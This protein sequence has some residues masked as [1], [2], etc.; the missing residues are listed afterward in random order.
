MKVMTFARIGVRQ[1][2]GS[3]DPKSHI[4]PGDLCEVSD[5]TLAGFYPV[6]YPTARGAKTRWVPELTGFLC[7]QNAYG[8][9]SYPA[10]GYPSATVKSGGC[11]VCAAVNAIGALCGRQV[12]V[13][14]M[15]DA[16]V[17]CGARVSGGT[18]MRRLTAELCRQYGL[19]C[20]VSGDVSALTAHLKAGG[21]AICNTAGRECSLPAGTMSPR[22]AC[23]TAGC[24]SRTRGCIPANTTAPG[25]GRRWGSAATWC[26][27]LPPLWTPTARGGIPGIIC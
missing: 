25:G 8:G 22:W 10:P 13:R 6:T 19:A 4:A 18:D 21:V 24:A 12:P 14:E 7:N 23:W 27:R 17:R 1:K 2:D 20:A 11:G 9:L 5:K 15:R 26:W 3:A 16:A